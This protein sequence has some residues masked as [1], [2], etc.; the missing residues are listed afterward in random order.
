MK[1]A[2]PYDRDTALDAAVALF[3]EKGYRATSLK[4]LEAALQMKPGSI[5]AAFTSKEALFL[6]ALERYVDQA[7]RE[8]RQVI[9][10][11]DSPLEG[12]C[13]Y[14]RRIGKGENGGSECRACLLIKTIL[15]VAPSEGAIADRTR[16][17]LDQLKAEFAAEFERAKA[18]GELAPDADCGQLALRYQLNIQALRIE[19][20]RGSNQAERSTLAESMVRD[21]RELRPGPD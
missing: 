14:L 16:Q 13:A 5:Y 6:T 11:A 2:T 21:L 17:H 7:R 19:S 18:L 10:E 9:D 1:R 8:F 20:H 15:D 4:D 12:L 3:W